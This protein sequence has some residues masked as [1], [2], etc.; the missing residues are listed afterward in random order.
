MS[1]PNLRKSENSPW[2][3]SRYCG[4][5]FGVL[6][7]E[8][9]PVH[10]VDYL[11][12]LHD[13]AYQDL[14]DNGK[15]K[16]A[17]LEWNYAD[18]AFMTGLEKLLNDGVKKSLHEHIV[19]QVAKGLFELKKAV[20]KK[21]ETQLSPEDLKA[22]TYLFPKKYLQYAVAPD[23]SIEVEKTATESEYITPDRPPKRI[24]HSIAPKHPDLKTLLQNA[25]R[26]DDEDLMLAVNLSDSFRNSPPSTDIDTGGKDMSSGQLDATPVTKATPVYGEQNTQTIITPWSGVFSVFNMCHDR[27]NRVD[28]RMTSPYDVMRTF[29][30]DIAA[31]ARAD[32]VGKNV[33]LRRP[34]YLGTKFVAAAGEPFSNTVAQAGGAITTTLA[35]GPPS[36]IGS[37]FIAS[38]TKFL[39]GGNN[40]ERGA[41]FDYYSNNYKYYTVLGC[42]YEI[43][44]TNITE[45]P[46]ADVMVG[47]LPT[48]RVKPPVQ[49]VVGTGQNATTYYASPFDAIAWKGVQWHVVNSDKGQNGINNILTITG[50]YR[51]GDNKQLEIM[52]DD[53]R[54]IWN[55]KGQLPQ[56]PEDLSLIF[57][58]APGAYAPD[59]ARTSV[60]V[61]V[62]LKYI[63]QF[64]ELTEAM[65][66]PVGTVN[67]FKNYT[68]PISTWRDITD[69]NPQ[70]VPNSSAEVS[71]KNQN[72]TA[73][74]EDKIR[75]APSADLLSE[76][77]SNMEDS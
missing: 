2:F 16:E 33:L 29:A 43:K 68:T 3:L 15:S 46:G 41:W 56:V 54:E 65:E 34:L 51:R 8:G 74:T 14:I 23:G 32:D 1:K 11:C 24:P 40:K 22:N 67:E 18:E 48:S 72:T 57:M 63:V 7:S 5:N 61:Y 27:I 44:V 19:L 52:N 73:G 13:N 36:A 47:C 20:V 64:K 10:A 50:T 53:K 69:L 39:A 26:E 28:L 60:N 45:T 42:E 35:F 6:R 17:Y 76:M 55:P 12:Y 58:K 25:E 62:R 77:D 21:G 66:Y 38:D 31:N 37:R 49:T 59:L 71:I 75:D 4:I 9:F 30:N 70:G